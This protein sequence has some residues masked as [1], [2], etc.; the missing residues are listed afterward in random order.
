MNHIRINIYSLLL[1]HILIQSKLDTRIQIVT[2]AHAGV[3]E[4][5]GCQ[6]DATVHE[7]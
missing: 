1:I 2:L 4:D 6:N 7:Y 3:E 5:D